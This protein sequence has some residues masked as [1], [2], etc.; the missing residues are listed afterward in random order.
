[1]DWKLCLFYLLF[2]ISLFFVFLMRFHV[3]TY[4]L[5]FL[6]L[7]LEISLP[8]AKGIFFSNPFRFGCLWRKDK[9]KKVKTY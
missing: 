1:M 5:F 8:I 9:N 6:A 3:L 2:F 7:P 4:W